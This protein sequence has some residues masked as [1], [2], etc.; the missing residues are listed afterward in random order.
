MTLTKT[1]KELFLNT[2]RRLNVAEVMQGLVRHEGE[3][4]L[5]GDLK[6]KLQEFHRIAVISIGK[7]AAPMWDALMPVLEAA[8]KQDQV[9]QAIVVGS[10]EPQNRDSRVRFFPGSHPIPNQVSGDSAEAI[11][12]LLSSCDEHCLVI[13]LISGG[14]SAMVE[15]ALDVNLSVED[16]ASF[17]R[18]LVQ[19][20]LPIT[21][22]NT[23]RKHF[24]Q[25]KG[26]RL[27]V[28]AQ[29]A[30]QCTLLISDVPE[31]AL[32]VVGSGPSL[33]DPS[34]SE[35]CRQIISANPG[36]LNFSHNLL[37]YFTDTGLEETPKA[38]HP[39]FKK[40]TWLSLLSSADLCR[41]AGDAATQLGFHAV[42]DNSC[43]DWD[44]RDAAAYL[45]D[46]LQEL[47]HHH[48][49]ICLVSSGEISVQIPRLHGTGGRNQQFVL[50]CARLI[51]ER[52]I[53][54]TILSGGSDGADGNS[55]AAGAIC[56]ETTA[57]RAHAHGLDINV[58]LEQFDSFNV[59]SKLGDA[60]ITG[61]TG[62][63]V[64]DLRILLCNDRVNPAEASRE[65][66]SQPKGN[67]PGSTPAHPSDKQE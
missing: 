26:G 1:A 44:Y 5:V 63:N 17:Y 12:Q 45:L 55:P 53:K 6:Y 65:P 20:G 9:I 29:G 38:N 37:T 14:A 33:P 54:A 21:Q 27:A 31:T 23:L 7:A 39:A 58:A 48:P 66:V 10:T 22:M 8:A 64:R 43:D 18:A 62:N 60:I 52:N 25:V 36:A 61:P 4:L 67:M 28:A 50:Q 49:K 34:T 51:A 47:R 56:D 35:E 13:F 40:S 32:H 3:T 57:T 15:K 46:R 30:T 24:S 41:I 59:F 16:T 11:L 42:V 19:S 2:L